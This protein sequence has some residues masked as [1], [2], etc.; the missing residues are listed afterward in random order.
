VGELVE[1]LGAGLG[2]GGAGG[3][4]G[5]DDVEPVAVGEVPEDL[6]VGDQ[7]ATVGGHDRQSPLHLAVEGVE[8]VDGDPDLAGEGRRVEG[9]QLVDQEVGD[10]LRRGRHAR[11]VG[12]EVGIGAPVPCELQGVDG[13]DR[14]ERRDAVLLGRLD[15]VGEALLEPGAVGDQ[16]VGV[17]HGGDLLGGRLELVGGG[18]RGHHHLD[19]GLVTDQVGDHV[20]QHVGRHHHVG[21][22]VRRTGRTVVVAAGGKGEE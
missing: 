20:A 22:A 2:L 4:D 7:R 18:P 5:A 8:V 13:V 14:C 19:V 15:R 10:A 3:D 16:R 11:G 9:G 17:A 12:E 6:V 21:A 1:L